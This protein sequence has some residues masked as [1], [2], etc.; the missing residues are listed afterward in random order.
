L[1]EPKKEDQTYNTGRWTN[2]EH[3]SMLEAL[4]IYGKDWDKI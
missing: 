2:E 3:D 4:R 1:E